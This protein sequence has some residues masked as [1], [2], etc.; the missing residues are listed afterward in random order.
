M[1]RPAAIEAVPSPEKRGECSHTASWPY[2]AAARAP[3]S[4]SARS[5]PD[6]L[7]VLFKQHHYLRQQTIF[8]FLQQHSIRRG[9][10]PWATGSTEAMEAELTRITGMLFVCFLLSVVWLSSLRG[11]RSCGGRHGL[12]SRLG[13]LGLFVF[14]FLLLGFDWMRKRLNKT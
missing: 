11:T 6:K 9:T 1:H 14:R 5:A 2:S 8:N 12:G 7:R 13:L 10:A 3:V 4:W